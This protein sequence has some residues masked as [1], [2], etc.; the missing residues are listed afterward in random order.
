[1]WFG[2][3]ELTNYAAGMH[4]ASN[5]APTASNNPFAPSET[6]YNVAGVI[7]SFTDTSTD[8]AAFPPNAVQVIWGDGQVTSHNAGDTISH[9]YAS[10][11]LFT[12]RHTVRDAGNLYNTEVFQVKMAG[13]GVTERFSITVNVTDN[14]NADGVPG[15]P[16]Q[17]ATVYLKKNT[18]SGWVQIKSGYTDASGNSTFGNLAS[19]KDYKVVVYKS[20]SGVNAFDFDGSLVGKQ[21][22]AKSGVIAALAGNTLVRVVQ[23]D[24]ATNGPSGKEWKGTNGTAPTIMVG[25]TP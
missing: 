4:S 6:P 20:G 18:P 15:A 1:M 17:G 23:G 11:G 12:I 3:T 7:V 5:T 13:A 19:G 25:P 16:I 2:T 8:N 21:T 9:T 22:K 24:N 14:S 10:A